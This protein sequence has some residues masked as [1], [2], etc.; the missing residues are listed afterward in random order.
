MA[1]IRRVKTSSGATAVQIAHKQYG[2]I[3]RIEHIGS[4]HNPE[5]E[6]M[7]VS[8]ARARLHANQ[9][10]L[11]PDIQP[12]LKV[13]LRSS[14][15]GLLR[16]VLLEQYYRLGFRQLADEVYALL[17]IARIVEPTSKLDSLRVFPIWKSTTLT[18]T[19]S[20]DVYKGSLTGIIEKRSPGYV[21]IGLW[22]AI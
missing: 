16:R 20:T 21:L 6:T 19:N 4:A 3:K 22:P 1:F 13:R 9:P 17:C 10:S 12:A 18:G 11:F 15:S 5:E 14:C 8:L 2:R 7:L